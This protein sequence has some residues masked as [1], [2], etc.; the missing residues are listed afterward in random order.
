M[1][2]ITIIII[3]LIIICISSIGAGI[4]LSSSSEAPMETTETDS[5]KTD[6]G[7]TDSGKTD[8]GK[9]DSGKTDSGKTDSG[10]TDSGASGTSGTSGT[11]VFKVVGSSDTNFEDEGGG[12]TIYLDRQ[13]IDC[14]DNAIKRFHLARDGTGKMK[15]EIT[16]SSGDLGLSTN[17]DTGANDWGGGN[18]IYLDRH[19]MDCGSDS[20]LSQ[21]RLVRPKENEIRY[22]YTCK[23]SNK[24]LTCRDVTTPANDW[25]GGN[26]I[27]L[28]RH[29]VSCNENEVISKVQLTRPTGG[30]ISYQYKCCKY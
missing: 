5:G 12:N 16:C 29:D 9:T 10:K 23:K 24:P 20:V 2:T 6:S 7:K 21:F 8:S 13:Q 25:G 17:K 15:Y 19:N 22:D 11:S 3:I 26:S 30:E 1:E 4:Y 28:D 14:K 18:S 27:Y